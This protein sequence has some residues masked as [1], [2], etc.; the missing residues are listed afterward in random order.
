MD[1]LI[2]WLAIIPSYTTPLLLAS[3]GLILS[4]RA[5]VLNLGAEGMMALGAMTA[6]ITVLA[7][8]DPWMGI[9]AGAAAAVA[10]SLLF[11]LAVVVF[12]ADQT[13]AG[14]AVVAIG[15]GVTGTVGRP[16]VQQTFGG[17][18]KLGDLLAL[19]PANPLG[20]IIAAQDVIS[21]AAPILALAAWWWLMKTQ[22]GLRLRAAGENPA[23]ADVAG[24]DIQLTQLAAV[25]FAGLMCGLAGAYLSVATSHVW[26]ENMVAARGWI[27]VALV[28]LAKWSPARAVIGAMLFGSADALVPR[29]QAIGADVPVYLMMMLPYALTLFVLFLTSLSGRGSGEPASLGAVYLRQDKH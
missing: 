9:A 21:L 15:L 6:A 11:G 14:L 7:G 24:V 28:I 26:V 16:Y 13:L 18:P 20:R 22:A 25:L 4:E 12:R 17:L 23:A 19:D 2:G 1:F 27:A 10:V 29:L 8:H 5:G 3:V